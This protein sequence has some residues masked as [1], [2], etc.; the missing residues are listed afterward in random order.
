MKLFDLLQN[1]GRQ[2]PR[3]SKI[4]ES[5]R[6][7]SAVG[8]ENYT[9]MVERHSIAKA[10]LN[11]RKRNCG[12]LNKKMSVCVMSVISGKKAVAIFSE[13]PYRYLGS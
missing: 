10:I 2:L 13:D 6:E 4:W 12:N 11:T 3:L 5:D 1:Q 9:K 7:S 8:N